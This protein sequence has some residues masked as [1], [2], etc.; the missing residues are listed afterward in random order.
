MRSYMPLGQAATGS[1]ASLLLFWLAAPDRPGCS[2]VRLGPRRR[3]T[4][5]G[6]A[7]TRP[8]PAL[9]AQ[10][11]AN[12][13]KIRVASGLSTEDPRRFSVEECKIGDMPKGFHTDS[14]WPRL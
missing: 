3:Q 8:R 10:L 13:R 2:P 4:A 5:L 7:R 11:L 1:F 9:R 6:H 14:F 12:R